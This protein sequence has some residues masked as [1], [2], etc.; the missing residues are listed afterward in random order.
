MLIDSCSRIHRFLNGGLDHLRHRATWL[1]GRCDNPMPELTLSPCQGSMNSANGETG[2]LGKVKH[3]NI[4]KSRT[5]IQMRSK[6]F[7]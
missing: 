6:L 2:Q 4:L 7:Y 1:V 5:W 3:C